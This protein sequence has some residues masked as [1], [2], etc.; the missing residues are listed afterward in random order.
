MIEIN[1]IREQT[2]RMQKAVDFFNIM[3]N[4]IEYKMLEVVAYKLEDESVVVGWE[5]EKETIKRK[6][7]WKF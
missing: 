1:R 5:E 2:E 3:V 6:I 4:D 7:K